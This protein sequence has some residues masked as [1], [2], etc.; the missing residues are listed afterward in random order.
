[1]NGELVEQK[2]MI[3]YMCVDERMRMQV[4]DARVFKGW[5]RE[6]FDHYLVIAKKKKKRKWARRQ[7]YRREETTSMKRVEKLQEVEK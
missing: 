1:M 6:L 3:D 7:R 2:A 5:G 4:L